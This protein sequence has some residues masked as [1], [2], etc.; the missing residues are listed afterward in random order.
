MASKAADAERPGSRAWT[1]ELVRLGGSIHQDD[2]GALADLGVAE[3]ILWSLHPL[4][5]YGIYQA[6]YSAF[7]ALDP[8]VRLAAIV[9]VVPDWLT[10]HGVHSSLEEV[11]TPVMWSRDERDAF[12]SSTEGW[13]PEHQAPVAAA[14][15]Q[16]VR[17]DAVW[18]PL[19][20]ALGGQIFRAPL[21]PIPPE[22]PEDWRNAAQ[23]FRDSGRVDAVWLDQRDFASN[24]S[25]AIAILEMSH[26][27]RWRDVANVLNP[28]LGYRRGELPAFRRALADLPRER[29]ERVVAHVAASR[30][31]AARDLVQ[32]IALEPNP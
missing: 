16:W 12:V 14:V 26:G 32:E 21:T 6:A 25:R 28:L 4:D 30:P 29:Y 2:D 18:E 20:A 27:E 8:S 22:W 3:A 31:A 24:F 1:V 15:A 13:S 19:Q 10:R 5:D 17:D 23:A 9:R 11:L 7:E